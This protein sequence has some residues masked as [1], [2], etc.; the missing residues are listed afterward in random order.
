MPQT[1]ISK[2]ESIHD[3]EDPA[4]ASFSG[5]GPNKILPNIFKSLNCSGY[6]SDLHVVYMGA[7]RELEYSPSSHHL[8]ILEQVVEAASS[9]KQSWVRNYARSFNAFA[10]Y[11][12]D[13]ER[14]KIAKRQLE[15]AFTP[16]I[17]KL[18]IRPETPTAMEPT[19]P[20]QPQ[21]TSFLTPVSTGWPTE[22]Q[23][24]A[25]HPPESPYTKCNEIKTKER[26]K[27]ENERIVLLS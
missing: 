19:L 23:E 13:Q 7:R 6:R 18:R 20:Q 26:L 2:S 10:A 14:Q 4:I 21:A 17:T 3:Y 12:T 9:F 27:K 1:N 16:K 8:N 11:L 15:L 5:R 24:A 22:L 25:S